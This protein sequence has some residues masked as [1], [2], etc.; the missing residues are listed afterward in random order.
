MIGG[1]GGWLTSHE[2]R[3]FDSTS[4]GLKIESSSADF[5]YGIEH[6]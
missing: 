6:Q 2:L 3:H 4:I 5:V 1:G